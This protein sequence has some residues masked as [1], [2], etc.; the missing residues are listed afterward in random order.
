MNTDSVVI[1]ED[2]EED[3]AQEEENEAEEVVV[4]PRR[5]L[6]SLVWKEFKKVKVKNI[7]KAKCNWCSKKLGGEPRNGTK[8]LLDHLKICPY[9]KRLADTKKQT[10]LRYCSNVQGGKVVVENY[11]FDLDVARKALGSMIL[12]HDYPLSIVDQIGFRKFVSTLQLLFKMV[13]RNT[14]RSDILDSYKVEKKRA[15]N[16]MEEK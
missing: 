5:K 15:I 1:E 3:E 11:T 6:T 13:R 9:R 2:I 10:S 8:H 12:L 16:Y 7:M 14:I 4:R